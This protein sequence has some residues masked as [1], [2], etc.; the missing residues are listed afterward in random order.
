MGVFL[1]PPPH[2]IYHYFQQTFV[3]VDIK[4]LNTSNVVYIIYMWE[5]W[6]QELCLL[7]RHTQ[8]IL[9]ILVW[10]LCLFLCVT[11]IPFFPLETSRKKPFFFLCFQVSADLDN[12]YSTICISFFSC[13]DNPYALFIWQGGPKD[14]FFL[15]LPA[16]LFPVVVGF[17]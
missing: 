3:Y 13:L 1:S 14:S 6:E 16:M 11:F 5:K 12:C 2:P 15:P 9:K 17:S 4:Y 10:S 8:H 7:H